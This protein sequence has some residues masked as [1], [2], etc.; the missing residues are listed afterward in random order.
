MR[1]DGHEAFISASIGVAVF[2]SDGNGADALLKNADAAMYRAKEAGR[3]N[4]QFYTAE[5]NQQATENLKLETNLRHALDREEFALHFQ[6]KVSLTTGLIT[7]FEALLRWRRPDQTLVSP[8]SFIPVL[9][10]TGLI[11][12]V[13]VWVLR[14]ACAQIRTWRRANLTPLPIAINLSARQFRR[15][16][17]CDVVKSALVEF[18]VHPRELELEITESTAM[19]DA[20]QAIATLRALR[21]LGV[22]VAIDDFGTGYSSL[23]YLKRLPV[24]SIKIDRSF[25][26]QVASQRDDAAIARAIITMAHSLQL[27]VIAEGVET[28]DQLAFL[29]A[30]GCDEVQGYYFSR[31]LPAADCAAMLGRPRQLKG[32]RGPSSP[33]PDSGRRVAIEAT[34]C[35]E[36]ACVE[37]AT[38]V[39]ALSTGAQQTAMSSG[40][41]RS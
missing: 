17:I 22:H 32:P 28:A 10:Q 36:P 35:E 40:G 38:M 16:D 7:G 33:P 12:P 23:S 4:V 39:A 3:A 24:D 29:T 11:V 31:P 5:M 6:P 19:E 20:D 26:S 2:P 15:Q 21:A 34:P 14:A 41:S 13:G 25:V 30:N 37:R 18:E 8:A 27:K 9:E 1:I